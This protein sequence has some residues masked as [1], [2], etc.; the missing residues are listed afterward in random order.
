[1]RSIILLFLLGLCCSAGCSTSNRK[2]APAGRKDLEVASAEA[3]GK[4]GEAVNKLDQPPEKKDAPAEEKGNL[5]NAKPR[6]IRYTATLN[7]IVEDLDKATDALDEAR[8]EA[9][10]EY[11]RVEVNTSADS[12]R[13]GM[14]RVR[15]PVDNLHSFRKAVAK[16]G[17]VT[18]NTLET[19]DMTAQYYDL[20]AD[21]DNRKS[22]R[23]ALRELLKETG[24]KEMKH[25]LE[26]WD[27]LEQVSNEINRKEGQ[28]K[29]W[30]DLTELTTVTVTLREKQKYIAAKPP[31]PTETPTFGMRA[32][33][34]WSESWDALLEFGE[35]VALVAIA[36]TP[37]LPVILVVGLVGWFV[38]RRVVR[39]AVA[40]AGATEGKK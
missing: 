26:V 33:K 40:V 29:L 22:A 21:I 37:W 17:E 6:K 39:A 10:G 20:A 16:L 11:A 15:V 7:L 34:T 38:G 3:V 32:G 30:A 35:G 19:E 2:A 23:E 12:V 4:K 14:W 8:K 1:M 36:V 31:E 13:V 9:K 28:L 24:K 5:A 25:Y 18:T 27:K